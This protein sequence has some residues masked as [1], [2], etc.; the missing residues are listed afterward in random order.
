MAPS[1]SQSVLAA[2]D[3]GTN[4][5]RL[6]LAR[7][8]DGALERLHKERDPIRPGEG[9]FTSGRM[10]RETADRL[11]ST[12]RR[13]A[14]LCQRHEARVRAV[15]TSAMRDAKNQ[16]EVIQRV[17]DETGLHLEVVSGEEE[18]RLICLGVLHRTPARTRSLLVDM[19]GGS[20]EVALATGER[21]EELWS[22]PLGAVRLTELF[23]TSGTVS[24][25]RL[26]L[27]RGYV[28]EA[29]R[30]ELPR[31]MPQLPR[32][33]LGSSGTIKAVVGFAASR[34]G[35]HASVNQLTRAVE[36]LAEMTPEERHEHFEPRRADIIVAGATL[37]EC[38]LRHLGVE[39][40]IAV[41]QGLR[42][43]ILVDLLY[44][45]DAA[46]DATPLTGAVLATNQ[47]LAFNEKHA[48]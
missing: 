17:H 20:T 18:A 43:G 40:V 37:L 11:V 27:M 48:R 4:A 2:I 7:P 35:A 25:E 31:N 32:V 22:L 9:V 42:K 10:P 26:R 30:E 23:E 16:A 12:L 13:Y 39:S 38:V 8:V 6:E 29:L 24:P 45:Q 21:P 1:T 36:L 14:V 33:A 34:G 5:V 44:R 3:V 19:G 41:K 46:N 47:R 28:E 15:A